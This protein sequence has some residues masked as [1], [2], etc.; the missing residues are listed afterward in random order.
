MA[1]KKSRKYRDKNRYKLNKH[2]SDRQKELRNK[3][4]VAY[5]DFGV[6]LC[7]QCGFGDVRA[8]NIDHVENNGSTETRRAAVLWLWL[9]N[10]NFPSGYQVLCANCNQIKEMKRRE[11]GMRNNIRGPSSLV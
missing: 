6:P 9:I 10:N 5:S 8:L 2:N 1:Q 4:L 7:K 3:V 11:V